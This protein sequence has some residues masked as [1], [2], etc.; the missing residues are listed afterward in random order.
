[1]MMMIITVDEAKQMPTDSA[2]RPLLD[3]LCH[4]LQ[5]PLLLLLL[6]PRRVPAAASRHDKIP[7]ASHIRR[8][9][10]SVMVDTRAVNRSGTERSDGH[11]PIHEAGPLSE[12][13]HCSRRL[14]VPLTAPAPRFVQTAVDQHNEEPQFA[15]R[16]PF[17]DSACSMLIDN[18]SVVRSLAKQCNSL[19]LPRKHGLQV[20]AVLLLHVSP[21]P[22]AST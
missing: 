16:Y 12:G 6:P 13:A 20:G 8:H 9:P 3:A 18:E 11:L 14:V 19:M 15:D 21:S 5:P 17:E 4:P 1:M 7:T 22:V 10:R 2:R